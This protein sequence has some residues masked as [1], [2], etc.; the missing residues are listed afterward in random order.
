MTISQEKLLSD[1]VRFYEQGNFNQ[2]LH[3]YR[4]VDPKGSNPEITQ[5]IKDCLL[6]MARK[7][8]RQDKPQELEKVMLQLGSDQLGLAYARLRGPA[9][10]S[11][12]AQASQGMFSML[13]SCSIQE[14]LKSGLLAMRKIPELKQFAEGWLGL[15]KGNTELAVESFSQGQDQCPLRTNLGLGTAYLANGDI[16][17]AHSRL[18]F[19]RPFAARRFPQ[20]SQAMGWNNPEQ[21]DLFLLPYYFSKATLEELIA[22]EK[23]LLPRQENLKGWILLR[24]GDIKAGKSV[25]EAVG[26]WDKARYY[27]FS[28]RLDVLKRRYLAGYDPDCEIKVSK[29]FLEFY[30]ELRNM[31][32]DAQAFIEHAVFESDKSLHKFL[33]YEELWTPK[34]KWLV[35]PPPV[36]MQLLWLHLAYKQFLS[37]MEQ[38]LFDFEPVHTYLD[39]SWVEW[40]Q[41]LKVLDPFYFKKETYLREKLSIVKIMKQSALI[42]D[43]V[44]R[45]LK[46]NPHL[47]DELLPLY[48]RECVKLLKDDSQNPQ[49]K[50]NLQGEIASLRLVFPS[51]FDLM[52]LTILATKDTINYEEH[53][54]AFK[55]M[56]S[57]PLYEVLKLQAAID[58]N[59]S[60]SQC[61][62]LFPPASLYNQSREADWRLLSAFAN[63][64]IKVTKKELEKLVE[65]LAPNHDLRHEFFKK[66]EQY[67]EVSLPYSLLKKWSEKKLKDWR[68]FYHL[69][70]YYYH[71]GQK[72]K[73]LTSLIK[74]DAKAPDDIPEMSGM[75][76]TLDHYCDETPP[77]L[78]ELMKEF[79]NRT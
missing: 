50:Q 60:F 23:K 49:L 39:M 53:L 1:A 15:L 43:T 5:K 61:K 38:I 33:G 10:L 36:E 11:K 74:A 75:Q 37:H 59:K 29:A 55:T 54:A 78:M 25:N 41:F 24:I 63:P 72:D 6:K 14:D 8:W 19:L 70:F 28:L 79:F 4:Q 26:Y 35:E 68:P 18:E 27:N 47:S 76:K 46:L 64:K 45:L 65:A 58:M 67:G 21:E 2:A 12:M 69:A 3:C 34:G 42:C 62:K 52:R 57:E 71:E 77:D 30:K 56:L 13:A 7:L 17:Q 16:V 44:A 32:H 73:C 51:D 9:E 20:L 40:D 66:F 22:V 31:P 48:V